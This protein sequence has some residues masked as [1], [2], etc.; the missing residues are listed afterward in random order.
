MVPSRAAGHP[1]EPFS[2]KGFYLAEFRGRTLALSVRAE[3]LRTPTALHEVLVELAANATRIVLISTDE[4]VFEALPE[5]PV[6]AAESAGLEGAIWRALQKSGRVGV[7]V[8]DAEAFAA[9]S[10]RLALRLR[11]MK[12]VWIEGVG[13][14]RDDQGRRLAFVDLEELRAILRD[15]LSDGD[16][17]DTTTLGEFEAALAA[18]LPAVNLCSLGG[19]ADDLFTYHGSGTLF[20]RERYVEVR[21]LGVDD[22]AAAAD[23]I[24][25]GVAEGY[26]APR[27]PDDVERV[28]TNGFG[29]FVEGRHLAGIGALLRHDSSKIGEIASLYTLTRFLGEGIGAHLVEHA[30]ECARAQGC[31]AVIAVTTSE[32]VQ[33]FFERNGFCRADA[34]QIPAEKWRGYDPERRRR[35][36]CLIRDLTG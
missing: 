6:L 27:S 20:S 13:V 16:V 33:G 2:E 14:L 12:L 22:F 5:T 36:R 7:R 29:A 23:L 10:A 19:L 34:E 3:E 15:G 31:G 26:L 17:L 32:R 8:G 9:V 35:A 21:A 24:A 11:V 18:G 25:R 28:L 4:R 30:C 1:V